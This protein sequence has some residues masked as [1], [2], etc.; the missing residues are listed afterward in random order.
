MFTMR[1]EPWMDFGVEFN[2]DSNEVE[3]SFDYNEYFWKKL[4]AEGHPGND[5]YEIIDNFI[6]DWG[7]KLEGEE[8]IGDEDV[9]LTRMADELPENLKFYK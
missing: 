8:Y 6:K 9:D 1:K 7:R 4:K 3:F 5:E 2:E